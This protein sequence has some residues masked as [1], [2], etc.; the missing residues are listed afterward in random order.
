MKLT[1]IVFFYTAIVS[2]L[3]VSK[4]VA[5]VL[6]QPIAPYSSEIDIRK[7]R[8]I[9]NITIS[10]A[11]NEIE[12][13]SFYVQNNSKKPITISIGITNL[14]DEEVTLDS[15]VID[16]K[17]L[18]E[19]YQSNGAWETHRQTKKNKFKPVLV[20]ELLVNNPEI[21][22]VN[23]K[24][25]TN[26]ILIGK[27]KKEYFKLNVNAP[28]HK[29]PVEVNAEKFYIKDSERIEPIT[30]KVNQIAQVWLTF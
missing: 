23:K 12:S 2:I 11:T 19:W 14:R 8:K 9:D 29:D 7:V 28:K 6:V 26:S 20:R 4:G 17:Y 13:A 27:E 3:G 10:A 25:K 22:L 5:S 24:D 1:G 16:T 15:S 21:I 30:L 18:I